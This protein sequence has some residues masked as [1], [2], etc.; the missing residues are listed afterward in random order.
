MKTRLHKVLFGGILVTVLILSGLNFAI[1]LSANSKNDRD[2]ESL[3]SEQTSLDNYV[4]GLL[5]ESIGNDGLIVNVSQRTASEKPVLVFRYSAFNCGSCVKFGMNKLAEY[6]ED[7]TS[8]SDLLFVQSDFPE[9]GK[10]MYRNSVDLGRTKL[11]IPV[12]NSNQP[13]FFLLT[14]NRIDHV[15][16]PDDRFSEYTDTYL[17]EMKTRYFLKK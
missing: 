16:I 10:V 11:D 17:Q 13:F 9:K 8:N 1:L 6:F 4:K 7:S 5:F 2:L 14:D 3:K 15:F 12:E